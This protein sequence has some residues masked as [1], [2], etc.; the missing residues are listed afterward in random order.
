[1][2][3]SKKNYERSVAF[4]QKAMD[5]ILSFC[6]MC[7]P[8]EAILILKGKSKKGRIYI[9]DLVIPPFAETGTTF[10]GFPNTFLPLD[11]SYVGMMHSHPTG[12]AIPSLEDLQNFFGLVSV[13]VKSPYEDNDVFAWDRNGKEIRIEAGV[14]GPGE[15]GAGR[16]SKDDMKDPGD[17]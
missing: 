5:G 16:D 15:D 11:T 17:A 4:S 7:H 9:E 3:F 13:I 10:A 14:R 1:M 12:P 2:I 6:K 8:D